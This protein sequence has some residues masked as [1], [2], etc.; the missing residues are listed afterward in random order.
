M[1]DKEPNDINRA[2]DRLGPVCVYLNEYR[3][4]HGYLH[5]SFTDEH[6]KSAPIGI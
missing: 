4:T 3:L 5:L 6:F 1:D 2:L